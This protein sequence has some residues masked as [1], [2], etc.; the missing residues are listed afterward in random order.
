MNIL[1]LEPPLVWRPIDFPTRDPSSHQWTDGDL[2]HLDYYFC[3]E[4]DYSTTNKFDFYKKHTM[5][6]KHK[7]NIIKRNGGH[8]KTCKYCNEEFSTHA[9]NRHIERNAMLHKG[10]KEETITNQLVSHINT[11][12]MGCNN[13]YVKPIRNQDGEGQRLYPLLG[14]WLYKLM[15]WSVAD[16]IEYNKDDPNR[17]DHLPDTHLDA[18]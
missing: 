10:L 15:K 12:T 13:Y 3:D 6:E 1:D 9:Y 2:K 7:D 11:I 18:L 16:P 8:T 14:I 5:C 17:Y 4:C